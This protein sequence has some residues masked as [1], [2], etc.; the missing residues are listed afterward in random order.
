MSF[1]S[2]SAPAVEGMAFL[3]YYIHNI[4]KQ[5]PC[6]RHIFSIHGS[7]SRIAGPSFTGAGGGIPT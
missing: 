5:Q 3:G 4:Q 2:A 1:P 7:R 6:R